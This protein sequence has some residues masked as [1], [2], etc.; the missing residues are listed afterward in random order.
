MTPDET[1]KR[2]PYVDQDSIIGSTWC[3]SD[4]FLRPG[5]IYG[6]AAQRAEIEGVEIRQNSPVNKARLQGGKINEVRAGEEWIGADL[7]I[8]CTNAWSPR[9]AALLG[10]K[11]VP[12]SPLKRYLWFIDRGG[13]ITPDI[14]G[15]MPMIITPKGAYCRPENRESLMVGWA[16]KTD[17]EP[18]FEYEDQDSVENP[19]SHTE[20]DSRAYEAWE[21]IA[22][23]L[24]DVADFN[25][26]SATTSG[27]YGTTPDH[28]PFLC[29]D[30]YRPNLIF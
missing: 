20:I 22:E 4:G 25:G 13:P 2:F 27:Y 29:Y 8:D 17:A 18:S 24:P 5:V 7:F 30:P 19:Y 16:H 14:L 21:A 10:G 6:E 3:Q 12:M 9:L 28:N 15:E 11:A 26:I 23:S 1:V